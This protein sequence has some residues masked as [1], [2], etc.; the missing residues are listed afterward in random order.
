MDLFT[1]LSDNEIEELDNFL[2]DLESD[3]SILNVSELDGLFTAVISSP[4]TIPP[5]EWLEVI[6]GARNNLRFGRIWQISSAFLP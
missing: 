6:W 5:S 4:D 3:E 1:P 2:L